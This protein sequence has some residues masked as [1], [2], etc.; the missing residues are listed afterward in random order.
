MCALIVSFRVSFELNRDVIIPTIFSLDESE[1]YSKF[2]KLLSLSKRIQVDFMDGRFVPLK[3]ISSSQLPDLSSFDNIF[4]A[5]LMVQSPRLFYRRIKDKGFKKIIFHVESFSGFDDAL[6]FFNELK[7]Q[8]VIP[9]LAIN[10]ETELSDRLI[11]SFDFFLI[12]GVHPGKE[13]QSLIPSTFDR[14]K[15][16]RDINPSALIQIDGGVNPSNSGKLFKAGANY[17][18]SGSFISESDEP[19]KALLSLIKEV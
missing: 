15:K 18:N 8:G 3:S 9:V 13:K 19:E 17:L 6:V 5:H 16:I 11:T 4:E 14:I 1:F 10:P 12:M 2:D 7:K